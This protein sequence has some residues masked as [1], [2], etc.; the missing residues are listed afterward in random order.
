SDEPKWGIAVTPAKAGFLVA[1]SEMPCYRARMLLTY[2][3]YSPSVQHVPPL[4][5]SM[6]MRACCAEWRNRDDM[7]KKQMPMSA[8]HDSEQTCDRNGGAARIEA[9]RRHPQLIEDAEK[10]CILLE[11]HSDKI[12]LHFLL[13]ISNAEY[14]AAYLDVA[15][16]LAKKKS[17]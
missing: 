15:K 6:S 3:P 9:L 2:P 12:P 10:L 1:Q 5:S 11:H 16:D 14:R 17:L 13:K 4:V 8:N 7:S